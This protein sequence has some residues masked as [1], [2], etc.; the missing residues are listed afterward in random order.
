MKSYEEGFVLIV[1]YYLTLL[2][3]NAHERMKQTIR[4]DH[5][6]LVA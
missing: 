5:E 6:G 3:H 1:S 4:D 2:G